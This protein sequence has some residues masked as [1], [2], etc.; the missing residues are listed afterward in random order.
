MGREGACAAA[1]ASPCDLRVPT[2]HCS[3]SS[4]GWLGWEHVPTSLT[5]STCSRSKVVCH[6]QA[7][8]YCPFPSTCCLGSDILDTALLGLAVPVLSG[9]GRSHWLQ[10]SISQRG[11]TA[12]APVVLLAQCEWDC[13]IALALPKVRQSLEETVR[14]FKVTNEELAPRGASSDQDVAAC[15]AA[16]KVRDGRGVSQRPD[17]GSV[18]GLWLAF[19]PASTRQARAPAAMHAQDSAGTDGTGPHPSSQLLSG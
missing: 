1:G 11:S 17:F 16:C 15:D 6:P 7:G 5:A 3:S 10:L 8:V 14:S 12:A 18:L 13:D 2:Q 19:P 4:A 9:A